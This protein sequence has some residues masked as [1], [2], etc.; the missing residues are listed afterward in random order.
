MVPP[1]YPNDSYPMLV[2]SGERVTVETPAQQSSGG[3]ATFQIGTVIA[4]PSGLR[5]LDRLLRKYGR[6]E[7]IRRGE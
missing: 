7:N 5:E 1:G 6:V 4:D 3:S 2:Q